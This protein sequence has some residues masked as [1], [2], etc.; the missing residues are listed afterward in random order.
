MKEGMKHEAE[1]GPIILATFVIP[2]IKR[3]EK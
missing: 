2:K 3:K 1:K